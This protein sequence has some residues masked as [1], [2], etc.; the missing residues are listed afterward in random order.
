MKGSQEVSGGQA[1]QGGR[2]VTQVGREAL[3]LMGWEH[4]TAALIRGGER[5]VVG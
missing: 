4:N 3:W 1:G 2:I 5:Y